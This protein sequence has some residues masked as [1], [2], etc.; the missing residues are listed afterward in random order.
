MRLSRVV[1]PGL[2]TVW[3]RWGEVAGGCAVGPIEE[4][5]ESLLMNGA[6]V[7]SKATA[8]DT[9]PPLSPTSLSSHHTPPVP[10][11]PPPSAVH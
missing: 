8:A 2:C 1:Y 9:I 6:R 10:P 4:W 7:A 5:S 11:Q 3:E